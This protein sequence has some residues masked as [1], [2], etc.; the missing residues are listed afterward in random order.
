[1][2]VLLEHRARA[3]CAGLVVLSFSAPALAAAD[4]PRLPRPR[5]AV[6]TAAPAPPPA[7]PDS[8]VA[9]A[10][11]ARP[12]GE[13][14]AGIR[15]WT[16]GVESRF[17][18]AQAELTTIVSVVEQDIT[19][20]SATD[21]RNALGPLE[22]P[23]R[24]PRARPQRDA[25][26]ALA[27]PGS[28]AE[29]TGAALSPRVAGPEDTACLAR[30]RALGVAFT[31]EAAIEEGVCFV[32]HPLKVSSLGSGV[33]IAPDAILNCATAEALARWTKDV[34]VPRA[35]E[36][37]GATPIRIV[38]GSTYVCR[39]RN[40]QPDAKLSE[41]AVGNAVDI[42]SIVFAEREPLDI[43]DRELTSPDGRFQI[44]IRS[45]SCDYFTTVLGPRSDE[46]HALHFHFDLA[47]RSGGYRL[48]DLL[49]GGEEP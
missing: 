42:S 25:R 36:L 14:K 26:L 49:A 47:E 44:A 21:A 45:G 12:A 6:E 48:C 34:L 24:V 32:P 13:A 5:P 20:E 19:A 8:V 39:T 23:A 31:K 35:R 40:N 17:R 38:H 28:P 15:E 16:E 18:S 22:P 46:S 9:R 4:A 3:C 1:M 7:A 43:H 2:S 11:R 41:H 29:A 30:L 10:P 27:V 33:E 37:I